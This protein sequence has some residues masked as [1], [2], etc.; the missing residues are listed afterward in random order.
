MND[1]A[2]NLVTEVLDIVVGTGFDIRNQNPKMM[3]LHVGDS[4][5]GHEKS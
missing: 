1:F 3:Q 4:A 2:A 5:G